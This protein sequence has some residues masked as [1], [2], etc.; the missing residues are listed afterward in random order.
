MI[1][2]KSPLRVS[3]LSALALAAI[4]SLP[5]TAAPKPKYGPDATLLRDSH[6]YVRLSPAP[7]FWALM[8]YYA[9]QQTGSAC[10][11]ASVAMILN[12]ARAHR[13]LSADDELVT[14]NGALKKTADEEWT[15]AVGDKGGGRPLDLLGP[16][17]EKAFRAYGF[18]DA[19]A[20]VIHVNDLSPATRKRVHDALV[21]N[22]K[23]DSDFIL[24]NFIQGSYTG[25]A[26]VGHIAPVAAYDAKT[27]RVLILD[28]D[29]EWYEPYWVSEETFLK[30]LNT[31]DKGVGKYRGIVWVKR[32]KQ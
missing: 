9:A 31:M 21:A 22:E 15:K 29:R 23:S 32:D 30:G 26:D 28:P 6:E 5:A 27:K 11:I 8:P 24:A 19:A 18:S 2:P 17:V 16:G 13:T 12:G 4:V 10:S 25:D 7:D 1:L 20:E 14:Q 3:I